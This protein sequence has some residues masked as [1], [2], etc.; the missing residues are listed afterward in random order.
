MPSVQDWLIGA[1]R[2]AN[3][4][5]SQKA[6]DLYILIV[7]GMKLDVGFS[8]VMRPKSMRARASRNGGAKC[9]KLNKLYLNIHLIIEL[10]H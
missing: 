2:S 6:G 7:S 10:N 8:R 4:S 9:Q 1:T 5:A 3:I